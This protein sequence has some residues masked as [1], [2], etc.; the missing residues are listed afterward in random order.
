LYYNSLIMKKMRA[1]PGLRPEALRW[2]RLRRMPLR[3]AR[4]IPALGL[5]L[6]A[7][8]AC[9]KSGAGKSADAVRLDDPEKKALV[10]LNVDGTAYTNDD[11]QKYVRATLGDGAGA[12]TV[13]ALS[14]LF[15]DF[16]DEKILLRQARSKSE[17]PSDDELR[18]YAE[19]RGE[20]GTGD[21]APPGK[22]VDTLLAERFTIEKYL[23][24]LVKDIKV[25][26]GEV[27]AYYAQH[28]SDYLQPEKL[29]VSQILLASQGAATEV[30]ERLNS[31]SEDEFRVI[32]RA[33]SAGPEAARGGVM[34]VFSAGQLPPELEK[35]IF[36]M[37]EG[38]I[39]RVVE[40]SYG[41]HIFRLDKK[42]EA[43]LVPLAD[44]AP[45]IKAKLSDAKA[46]EAVAS[47]IDTLKA[48][49]DWRAQTPNLPFAYQRNDL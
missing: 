37:K 5:C 33:R 38:E 4:A 49:I 44:A 30:R 25:E 6:A 32:A 28:K 40:S 15:D 43:R 34:G 10:V 29:Q 41:Y 36:P 16:C 46:K 20:G 17:A 45:S 8:L 27:A 9:G 48:G 13:P 24:Q 19:R 14:R 12:L 31:V 11:F 39:S 1:F 35:F 2:S 23:S 18:A 7:L 22:D 21:A 26:D 47:H 3:P 42:I